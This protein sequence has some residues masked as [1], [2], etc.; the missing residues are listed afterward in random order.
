ML[1]FFKG[2]LKEYAFRL[3]LNFEPPG[4]STFFCDCTASEFNNIGAIA[5]AGLESN[6]LR[7]FLRIT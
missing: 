3:S 2:S 4:L 1:P 5:S 7:N 6:V